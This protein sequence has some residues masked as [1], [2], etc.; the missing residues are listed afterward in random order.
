MVLHQGDFDYKDDPD[1][2]DQRINLVLGPDFPYFASIGNHDFAFW[3]A[4]IRDSGRLES[5]SRPEK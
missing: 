3:P 2:W 1:A 5:L 4:G